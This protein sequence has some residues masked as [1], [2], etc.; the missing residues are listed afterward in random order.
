MKKTLIALAALATI[1]AC[2][3]A[4]VIETT[5]DN[6]IGFGIPF[7]ENATKATDNTYSGT[8]ALTQFNVYGTVT[9]TA[10]T[11]NIFDGVLVE[12]T[13]GTT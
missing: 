10:G 6:L 5:Q 4:E 7:V 13:V 3:K 9:G 11:V 1:A 2:N 12:G 8:K